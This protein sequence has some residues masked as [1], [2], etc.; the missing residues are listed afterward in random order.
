MICPH[1]LLG[2]G[3]LGGSIVSAMPF[4]TPFEQHLTDSQKEIWNYVQYERFIIYLTS[5]SIAVIVTKSIPQIEPWTRAMIA[6]TLTSSLYMI[7]PKKIYMSDH[8][9]HDQQR[10]LREQYTTQQLRYYGSITLAILAIPFV[11]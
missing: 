4:K 9:T 2:L 1:K 3:L 6:L 5:M 11:C 7:L 10:L 8:L